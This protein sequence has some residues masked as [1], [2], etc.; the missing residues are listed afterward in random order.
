MSGLSSLQFLSLSDNQITSIP[1]D[2][3]SSLSDLQTL[4]LSGNQIASIPDNVFSG[5]PRLEKLYLNHNQLTHLNLSQ[6]DFLHLEHFSAVPGNT[7]TSVD[8]SEASLSQTAFDAIVRDLDDG[9]FTGD[10]DGGVLSLNLRGADLSRVTNYELM[11]TW[12]D[13]E[14]IDLSFASLGS[15]RIDYLTG[16]IAGLNDLTIS[17]DQWDD[18]SPTI[19]NNLNAWNAMAGNTLAIVVPEPNSFALAT[20]ALGAMLGTRR[21]QRQC[22]RRSKREI[23]NATTV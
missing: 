18:F 9:D 22:R 4:S 2:A 17:R 14:T 3:F 1:S 5:L 21:R 6:V 19:Q 15:D 20:L 8:L 13:L 7:I 10:R 11:A 23:V 16:N 12:D